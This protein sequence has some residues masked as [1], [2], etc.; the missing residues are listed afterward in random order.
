VRREGL[1][2]AL[3]MLYPT[4]LAWLYIAALPAAGAD[5]RAVQAVWLGGKAVECLLPL[6]WVRWADGHWPRPAPPTRRGLA[7]GVGSGLAVAALMLLL[8]FAVL[9]H[10]HLFHGAPARVRHKLV[11]FGLDAPATFLASGVFVA[12]VHS[13]LEEYYWRWFVFGRLQ[14][15]V[16]AVA[17]GVLSSAAFAAFHLVDLAAFFPGRVL[18]LALPLA[19]C[20]GVGGAGWCWLYRRS[21][22]LYGPW[23]CHLV[24]DVALLVVGYDLAFRAPA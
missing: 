23:L 11:E 13:L 10:H 14:R 17:A 7:L 22:S 16:P 15:L 19:V 8:Y 1:V 3:A 20:V 12:V 18:T 5:P 21:G 2:L 9:R 4:L 6:L 24:L